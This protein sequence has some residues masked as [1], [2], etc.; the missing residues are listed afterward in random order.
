MPRKGSIKLTEKQIEA[1]CKN[2]EA[3][4]PFIHSALA[5]GIAENTFFYWKKE[6]MKLNEE[7]QDNHEKMDD[8][9]K[10][11]TK[12]EKILLKFLNG[13]KKAEANAILRN[14]VII[15]KAAQ[16]SWQAGAWWLE[17][18]YP[19]QFGRRLQM[20]GNIEHN[21]NFEKYI[22]KAREERGLKEIKNVS[23]KKIKDK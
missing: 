19:E 16:T 5:A 20:E 1:L 12:K 11:G 22:K 15:N 8:I 4:V 17:R 13:I 7:L 6:A 14:V 9:I 10:N 2:I 3:G 23:Q 18:R 21:F